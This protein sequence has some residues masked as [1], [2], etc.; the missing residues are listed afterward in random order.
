MPWII[1]NM[2]ILTFQALLPEHCT[3]WKISIH[4]EVVVSSAK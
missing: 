3:I 1:E 2:M 4:C